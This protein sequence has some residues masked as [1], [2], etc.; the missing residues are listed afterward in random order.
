MLLIKDD[1][2]TFQ[3]FV[4][5]IGSIFIQSVISFKHSYDSL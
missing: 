2:I 4:S 5:K 1:T 3:Y